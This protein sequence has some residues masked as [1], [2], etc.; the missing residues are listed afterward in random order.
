MEIGRNT[1]GNIGNAQRNSRNTMWNTRKC[2]RR[3]GQACGELPFTGIL[4]HLVTRFQAPSYI[5]GQAMN[6]K[7]SLFL[8]HIF[9]YEA[10]RNLSTKQDDR[11]T[12]WIYSAIYLI[13]LDIPKFIL[14]WIFNKL[15]DGK[16]RPFQKIKTGFH[17]IWL[18]EGHKHWRK[19]TGNSYEIY[20]LLF[21]TLAAPF[22]CFD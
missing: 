20:H 7:E 3:W 12:S 5:N 1:R 14:Q 8:M 13:Y 10:I 9:L 2:T 15:I 17:N 21:M 4:R 22:S 11:I 16:F 19:R 18:E 6:V